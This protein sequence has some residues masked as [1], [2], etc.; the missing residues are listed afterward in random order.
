M[1]TNVIK[2]TLRIAATGTYTT[3]IEVV[4][5]RVSVAVAADVV[6]VSGIVISLVEKAVSAYNVVERNAC[7]NAACIAA[8]KTNRIS[9]TGRKCTTE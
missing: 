5:S 2:S 6:I 4:Y 3:F 7:A 8:Y 9:T 1:I